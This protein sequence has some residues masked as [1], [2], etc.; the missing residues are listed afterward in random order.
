MAATSSAARLRA[1]LFGWGLLGWGLTLVTSAAHSA[2]LPDLASY[3]CSASAQAQETRHIGQVI[4]GTYHEWYE[5][6]TGTA[7]RLTCISVVQP[8]AQQ[9]S[10]AEAKA[11]LTAS[12]AV[13]APTADTPEKDVALRRA[14]SPIPKS[15]KRFRSSR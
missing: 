13:G 5:S 4:R 1:V 11:F 14:H 10:A 8:R 2:Q 15:W 3:A 12:F 6:Y 7:Q 9:L